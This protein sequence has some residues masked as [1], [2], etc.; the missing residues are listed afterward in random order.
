MNLMVS[1]S[2]RIKLLINQ[3]YTKN[4]D[5][6]VKKVD[7]DFLCKQGKT[8]WTGSGSYLIES[9]GKFFRN[10]MPKNIIA[11]FIDIGKVL[12]RILAFD[13]QEALSAIVEGKLVPYLQEIA[14]AH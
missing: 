4:Q 11:N 8:I 6:M 13:G 7:Q 5:Y 2:N 1:E 12:G 9:Q 3:E 10:M 14:K